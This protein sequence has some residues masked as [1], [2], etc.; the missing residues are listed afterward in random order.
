MAGSETVLCINRNA[1]PK[2]WVKPKSVVPL[3]LDDFTLNCTKAGFDFFN[4]KD[5]EKNPFYKQIIPYIVLQTRDMKKTAVYNRQGSEK[6]LHDLW[7]IGIGGHI[8]PIDRYERNASFKQI[9]M[10][11]MERELNEEMCEKPLDEIPVFIGVI[12]EDITDVGKVHL[13]AT[14]RILTDHP[15]HYLP[16]P[17][18]FQFSWSDTELLEKLNMELWSTL[19]LRLLSYC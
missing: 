4:R 16:G 2:S 1:L 19:A 6:R 11:G 5:V 18:L 12:S 13:G 8:N 15:E 17:E 7:S 9:L 10:A 14:F 3:N